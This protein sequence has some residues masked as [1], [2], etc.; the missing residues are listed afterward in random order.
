M[1]G[2]FLGIMNDEFKNIQ[3]ILIKKSTRGRTV[4]DESTVDSLA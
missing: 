4:V 3:I 2:G 1:F